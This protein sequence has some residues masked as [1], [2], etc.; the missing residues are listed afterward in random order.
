M[1]KTL[2]GRLILVLLL[3]II[4]LGVIFVLTTLTTSRQYYR[5]ITQQL[6][7]P[8]AESL[9]QQRPDLMVGKDVNQNEFGDLAHDLAMTNPGVEVYVLNIDGTIIGSSVELADLE[10]SKVDLQPIIKFINEP[11]YP[12]LGANPRSQNAKKIF[13]AA[14]LPHDD[15]YLYVLLADYQKDS[16]IRTVQTSTTLRLAMWSVILALLLVLAG[17]VLVFNLLTRRLRNLELAMSKFKEN[18]FILDK[19]LLAIT[20][21]PKDEIDQL[22][23]VFSDMS[24]K[25]SEHVT[26]LKE[27]DSLRRELITNVSH[28]LRTPLAALNG[29]LETLALKEASLSSQERIKYLAAAQKNSTRLKRLIEDLFDLSRLDAKAVKANFEAFPIQE[30]VQDIIMKFKAIADKKNV[31]LSLI[32]DDNMDFVNADIGL[33]ERLITNLLDNAIRHTASGGEVKLSLRQKGK[34]VNIAV[35]DTGVGIEQDV[36]KHIFERFYRASKERDTEGSGLGLAISKRIIALH[37]QE[38]KVTS[39][40]GKGSVFSFSLETVSA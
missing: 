14:K 36:L 23:N 3:L 38:I 7:A 22:A 15:G 32:S 34:L 4:P 19:P 10:Q 27:L 20:D 18:K 1:P 11:S 2:H 25:V 39:E 37:N 35:A 21:S 6:N 31:K 8:L 16:V 9:S 29:Y 30:L 40:V 13:S 26:G 12:I 24:L 28:D 33:I 5:E 17:G